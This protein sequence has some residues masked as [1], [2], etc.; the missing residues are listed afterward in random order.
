MPLDREC[1]EASSAQ[2]GSSNRFGPYFRCKVCGS[3]WHREPGRLFNEGSNLV[4]VYNGKGELGLANL[5]LLG[6]EVD[7][8]AL[9]EEIL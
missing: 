1:C 7:G 8:K 3:Y 2:I 4:S 9:M 5:V 6:V